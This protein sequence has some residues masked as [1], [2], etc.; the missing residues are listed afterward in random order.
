MTIARHCTQKS[1][2]NQHSRTTASRRKT[3]G[4]ASAATVILTLDGAAKALSNRSLCGTDHELGCGAC[5][6]WNGGRM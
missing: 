1:S 4:D 2:V 6:G 3:G 5:E